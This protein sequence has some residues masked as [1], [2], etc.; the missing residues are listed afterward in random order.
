MSQKNKK[1][2]KIEESDDGGDDGGVE[3]VR[4]YSNLGLSVG[5]SRNESIQTMKNQF[6]IFLIISQKYEMDSNVSIKNL[7][8]VNTFK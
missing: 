6:N 8:D 2:R 3:L 1:R 5:N 7:A 4:P